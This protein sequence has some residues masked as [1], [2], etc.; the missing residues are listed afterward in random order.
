MIPNNKIPLELAIN[1]FLLNKENGVGISLYKGG[2]IIG[3]LMKGYDTKNF[4]WTEGLKIKN[5]SVIFLLHFH[6]DKSDN[7]SNKLRFK[8]SSFYNRFQKKNTNGEEIF[9]SIIDLPLFKKKSHLIN[10]LNSFLFEI[11]KF[12][13]SEKLEFSFGIS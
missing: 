2:Y 1:Q 8:E 11:Y 7:E 12:N 5:K 3:Q 4:A 9:V 10:L 6:K 13:D